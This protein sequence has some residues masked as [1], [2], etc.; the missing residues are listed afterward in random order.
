MKKPNVKPHLKELM[1]K[2]RMLFQLKLQKHKKREMLLIESFYKI[3]S[4]ERYK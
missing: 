1:W 3:E 4:N 2:N